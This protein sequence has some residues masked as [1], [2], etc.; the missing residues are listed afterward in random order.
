MG[1]ASMSSRSSRLEELDIRIGGLFEMLDATLRKVTELWEIL[2]QLCI[3]RGQDE[4]GD[5]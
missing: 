4:S 5:I 2:Q 3:H 1:S